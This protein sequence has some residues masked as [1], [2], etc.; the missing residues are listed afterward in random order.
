MPGLLPGKWTAS[1]L[2]LDQIRHLFSFN[3]L[4]KDLDPA[5]PE[6]TSAYRAWIEKRE[7]IDYVETRFLDRKDDLLAVS[8]KQTVDNN[9]EV[10]QQPSA[11]A[12]ILL[13]PLSAAPAPPSAAVVWLPMALILPLMAF[14]MIPNLIGR[15]VVMVLIGGAELKVVTS[16]PELMGFMTSREW[17]IAGSV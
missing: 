12:Q 5:S 10:K 16:T 9:E 2:P 15:L 6:A 11:Q 3:N 7:P 13:A 14:A 1:G 4:L 17:I 8:R